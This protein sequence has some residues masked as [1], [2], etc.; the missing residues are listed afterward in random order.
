MKVYP[1]L[2][3]D[4]AAKDLISGLNPAVLWADRETLH[5]QIQSFWETQKEILITL[6]VRTS[7]DLLLQS[8]DLPSGSE[9][10]MSAVNIGHMEEIVKQHHCIPIFV[11]IDSETLAPS[12]EQFKLSIWI[13][14]PTR[15]L[16]SNLPESQ[17]FA[18]RRLCAG[19]RWYAIPGTCRC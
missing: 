3:L 8:L 1:R 14:D 2:E 16:R 12:V 9:I 15:T 6:C 7:F 13:G 5:G 19:L 11:D 18:G 4:I 10:I 17:Y